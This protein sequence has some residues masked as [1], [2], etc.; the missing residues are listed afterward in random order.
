MLLS[1]EKKDASSL[2]RLASLPALSAS[3]HTRFCLHVVPSHLSKFSS[4]SVWGT[5]S[6]VSP[7]KYFTLSSQIHSSVSVLKH[8]SFFLNWQSEMFCLLTGLP[9]CLWGPLTA[10]TSRLHPPSASGGSAQTARE[11][12]GSASA[13]PGLTSF[14]GLPHL[15]P[16]REEVAATSLLVTQPQTPV[17]QSLAL[18]EH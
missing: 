6:Q 2:A 7:M 4:L 14:P 10:L 18:P 13:R 5:N 1:V 17:H 3:L 8:S 9:S 16:S 12:S 11:L 15:L